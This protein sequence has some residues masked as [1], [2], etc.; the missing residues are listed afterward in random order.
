MD[1]PYNPS[2]ELVREIKA[3]GG[4]YFDFETGNESVLS[5]S[6]SDS[7]CSDGD[8]NHDE[9]KPMLSLYIP[10]GWYHWL[11]GMSEWTLVFGNSIY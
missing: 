7:C 4:Y 8:S 9:L 2:P 6:G 10:A 11:T 3:R 1:F 5:D